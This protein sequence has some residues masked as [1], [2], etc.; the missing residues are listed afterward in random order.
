MAETNKYYEN[1]QED[2]KDTSV[3]LQPPHH[4]SSKCPCQAWWC[5]PVI[6]AAQDTEVGG[7]QSV[8]SPGKSRRQ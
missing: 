8:F 6:P 1:T 3:N 7:S 2:L 4:K 5:T